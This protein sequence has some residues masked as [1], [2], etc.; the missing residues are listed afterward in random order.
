MEQE[1]K[2][3]V[4]QTDAIAP[5]QLAKVLGL[6]TS[7]LQQKIENRYFDSADRQL[8]KR[9][10][11]LRLRYKAG[12][13]LQ[14]VKTAGQVENGLHQRQEWEMPL[15]SGD[16]DLQL[17]RQ[18]ALAPLID[19][20]A[21][22]QDVQPIFTTDFVRLSWQF[23]WRKA[24]VEMAY[25]RGSVSAGHL[26]VA[27]HEVEL[28]LLDGDVTVLD[29]IADMLSEQLPLVRH[30]QSKAALGYALLSRSQQDM[31]SG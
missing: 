6:S 22:W 10:V 13:W 26:Q 31:H 18:T 29:G 24:T 9:G 8:L 12:Q 5:E 25:D 21:F 27:I 19:D 23:N 28:E 2:L 30:D 15:D 14:T 20:T 16:L 3:Q 17:L 4:T 7:P 1:I 11:A